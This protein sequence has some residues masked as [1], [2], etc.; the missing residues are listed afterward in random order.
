M[1]DKKEVGDTIPLYD[2]VKRTIYINF[3]EMSYAYAEL[4][5]CKR[6]EYRLAL[7]D[8]KKRFTKFFIQV[9]HANK[10]NKLDQEKR[11]YLLKAYDNLD[12]IEKKHANKVI[13]IS[14]ELIELLGITKIEGR[15]KDNWGL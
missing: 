4:I 3:N 14:R 1:V 6:S 2:E 11:T 15:V 5:T 7:W 9:N 12:K 10:L 8:F 13:N